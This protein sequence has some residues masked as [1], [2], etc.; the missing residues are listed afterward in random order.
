MPQDMIRR[1]LMKLDKN[2]LPYEYFDKLENFKEVE[3]LDGVTVMK[4]PTS[5]GIYLSMKYVKGTEIIDHYHNS[6]EYC[7]LTKGKVVINDRIELVAGDD[8]YFK[9]FE[10]HNIKVLE[11][12]EMYVQ[13]TKDESFKKFK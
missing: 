4:L 6:K 13:F 8:F 11:E 1:V 7:Y 5:K 10:I 9:P 12:S 2:Y 3:V